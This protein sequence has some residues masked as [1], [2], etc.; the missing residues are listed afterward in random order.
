MTAILVIRG[1]DKFSSTLREAGFEVIN[2]ELIETK[3]LED[4]SELRVKL[5]ELGEYDAIFFTSPVAARVF[6]RERE[7]SNGFHGNIYALGQRSRD[8]L[9]A[10]GLEVSFD[11]E[12]NTVE[13]LLNRLGKDEFAGK[14][15]LFVRGEASMRTIPE[16]LG[17]IARIDEVAVYETEK[18]NVDE[19]AIENVRSR[20][21]KGEVKFIC[22]FSPSGVERF[23]EL[24]GSAATSIKAT[25]IGTTT[26]MATQKAGFKTDYISPRSNADDFARGLIEHI[27]N[28]E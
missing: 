20:L 23:A 14:R 22:F 8:V 4:L 7:G 11:A 27:K 24:F 19:A 21:M 16:S 3:P 12:A 5:S 18:S 1:H 15:L 9:S 26:A 28:I 17:G 25:A 2:L 10:V 6:V 13:E